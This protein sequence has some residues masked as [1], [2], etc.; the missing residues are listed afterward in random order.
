MSDIDAAVRRLWKTTLAE[1]LSVEDCCEVHARLLTSAVIQGCAGDMVKARTMLAD[2]V[3]NI[4]ARL[5]SGEIRV[6]N[7]VVSR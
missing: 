2:M 1:G 6:K 3:K 7:V 4:G 5:E